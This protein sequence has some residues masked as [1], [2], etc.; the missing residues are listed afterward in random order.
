M[1]AIPALAM[2]LVLALP[3]A[4]AADAGPGAAYLERG[5]AYLAQGEYAR[6]VL[7]FEQVLQLEYLGTD[8]RERAEAYA[9]VARRNR[10][11]ERLGFSSFAQAGLGY[12]RENTTDSTRASGA[13]PARDPF[14]LAR[15]N[16]GATY[17]PGND[18]SLDGSLDYRFRYYDAADRRNDSDLRWNGSA[19]RALDG[20]SAA[21]G[22]RGR[23]SYR[24]NGRYRNDFG[25][26]VSR[27]Y[28]LDS[29]HGIEATADLRRRQYPSSLAERNRTN[30]GL[31]VS[32]T[33][34]ERD[35][36]GSLS[37]NAGLG[38]EWRRSS[39]PDGDATIYGASVHWGRDLGDSAS[40]F[41]FGWYEHNGFH[42]DRVLYDETEA[43]VGA[44]TRADDLFE[45]GGGLVYRLGG[46]W[47]VR[48]EILYIRDESN[49][50]W[51]NYSSTELWVAVR[52]VF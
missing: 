15:L 33:R 12:Y 34:A 21:V 43:P 48:P 9:E 5:L 14:V 28:L 10:R 51:G 52:R 20:G 4:A 16:G 30:A 22:A 8:A 31:E 24:G 44:K 25:V 17:L 36:R 41:L 47:T 2:L 27:S 42:D 38:Y 29:D 35:G 46:G 7:E 18:W 45:F 32:W 37:I 1:R 6:A 39:A 40:V 50:L 49:T 13:D 23:T 26:F 19:R 3:G 11:G